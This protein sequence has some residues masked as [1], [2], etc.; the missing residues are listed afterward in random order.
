MLNSYKYTIYFLLISVLTLGSVFLFNYIIDPYGRQN[1]FCDIK[2]KPVLNERGS[3]YHHIFYDNYIDN[4]DSLILG[5]SRV[6]KISPSDSNSTKSF[7][8]FS[9]HVAN[10]AE[11]LFLIKE[12]LKRKKLK[13]VYLGIDYYNFHKAKR[14]M[15]VDNGLYQSRNKSSYLS[16]NTLKLSYKSLLNK[17]EDRPQTFFNED[18]SIN[19]YNKEKLIAEGKYDFSRAKFKQEAQQLIQNN[20]IDDKFII[21]ER[22]F[23]TLLEI[24]KLSKVHNFKLK[25]FITPMQEEVLNTLKKNPKLT[26]QFKYI[27]EK[28]GKIFGTIYDFSTENSYNKERKNFYDV[29]HYRALL[30]DKILA[31]LS[32]KSSDYGKKIV[33]TSTK[34]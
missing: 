14:A 30:G 26:K 12:W 8:N 24:A 5:S 21:D 6:M 32:G 3:K 2:Y 25:V 11:K 28:T 33:F 9:V 29:Y 16:L 31:T 1:Y 23:E 15:F 4:Y 20:M 34:K 18:G 19:Y 17:I 10:N 27:R 13:T 7:Y 22:V